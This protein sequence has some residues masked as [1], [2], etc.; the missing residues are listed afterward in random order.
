MN[1]VYLYVKGEGW[2]LFS[3]EDKKEFESRN[4]SIGSRVSICSGAFIGVRASIGSGASIGEGVSPKC[5][6]IIGSRHSESY[7]GEDAIQIGCIKKTI[8]EW[9]NEYNS[10]GKSEKY[11]EDQIKEYGKY[12]NL[13]KQA[14]EQ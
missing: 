4:I 1:E 13:I 12:I 8:S 14:H 5:I 9:E 10:I 2:K 11:T 3:L 6:H 7:W